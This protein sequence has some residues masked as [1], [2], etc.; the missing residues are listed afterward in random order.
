MASVSWQPNPEKRCLKCIMRL[1]LCLCSE[2]PR[3]ETKTRLVLLMHQ[4]ELSS[5]SNTGRLGVLSLKNSV[6]LIRGRKNESYT[7]EDLCPSGYEGMV[8]YPSEDAELLTQ[9]LVKTFKKPVSL[10]VPDGNRRQAAKM[11]VRDPQLKNFRKLKLKLDKASEYSLRNEPKAFGLAT[12]E[13]IARAFGIL[14]NAELQK[15]LEEVFRK[16][17]Y[18]CLWARGQISKAEVEEYLPRN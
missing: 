14:E 4:K 10:V 13:A 7:P 5:H 9:Y 3:L 17:N 8:L 18:R 2:F 15:S 6:H 11:P 12:I 16:M 1:D